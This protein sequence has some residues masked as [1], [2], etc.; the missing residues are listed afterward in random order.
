MNGTIDCFCA[1]NGSVHKLDISPRT[2]A[3]FKPIKKMKKRRQLDALVSNGKLPRRKLSGREL[4]RPND[5][6]SSEADELCIF[7]GQK[8]G[9]R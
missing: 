4:L 2:N 7:E 9:K 3:Q 5:S 1:Q 6:E 8:W